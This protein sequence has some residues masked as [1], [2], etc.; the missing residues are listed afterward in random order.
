MTV[1]ELQPKRSRT[2]LR[3]CLD[4]YKELNDAATAQNKRELRRTFGFAIYVADSVI[5]ASAGR[6]C[7][8]SDHDLREYFGQMGLVIPRLPDDRLW[9]VIEKTLDAGRA[10]KDLRVLVTARHLI[11]C[12]VCEYSRNGLISVC[13]RR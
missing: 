10:A 12:W 11:Q 2:L 6:N 3:N 5:S 4:I 8:I 1:V 13:D 7:A 9:S